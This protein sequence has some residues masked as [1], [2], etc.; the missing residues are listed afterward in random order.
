MSEEVF[1]A[2]TKDV[3]TAI[4]AVSQK[5]NDCV[6]RLDSYAVMMHGQSTESIDTTDG[7]LEEIAALVAD[8]LERVTILEEKVGE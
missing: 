4:G 6:S 7:G 8:L 3:A 2:M 5:V 1:Y